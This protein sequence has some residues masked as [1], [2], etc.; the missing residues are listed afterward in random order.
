MGKSHL[1]H[2][3]L[4]IE[5]LQIGVMEL[6]NIKIY[7][8]LVYIRLYVSIRGFRKVSIHLSE[9]LI[10]QE[11]KLQWTCRIIFTFSYESAA[12]TNTRFLPCLHWCHPR[13]ASDCLQFKAKLIVPA[14]CLCD[15]IPLTV[16]RCVS[17][18]M[19]KALT[20]QEYSPLSPLSARLIT[21]WLPCS[22][23]S[24]LLLN[25]TC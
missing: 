7:G 1:G 8:I 13:Q 23:F 9:N 24:T 19:W 15:V 5:Y 16:T 3:H 22:D 11:G 21:S 20:W 25:T 10:Q 2:H 4:I 14:D 12:R 18:W 17:S 6:L